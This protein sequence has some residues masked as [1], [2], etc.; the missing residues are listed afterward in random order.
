[1]AR[2]ND[3]RSNPQLDVPQ[4][5]CCKDTSGHERDIGEHIGSDVFDLHAISGIGEHGGQ[6]YSRV[7]VVQLLHRCEMVRGGIVAWILRLW[8]IRI[9]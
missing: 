5:R 4:S 9:K 6:W 7:L 8:V 3:E 2:L 1:M